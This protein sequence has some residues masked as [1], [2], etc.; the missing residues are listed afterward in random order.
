M[1][2]VMRISATLEFWGTD[3]LRLDMRGASAALAC[4]T[5]H[6]RHIAAI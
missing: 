4:T 5:W 2:M 3:R 1:S 6:V